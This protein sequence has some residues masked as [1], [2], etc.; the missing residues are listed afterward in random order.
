[1]E[2]DR[3]KFSKLPLLQLIEPTYRSQIKK[4]K[5][6]YDTNKISVSDLYFCPNPA[7]RESLR[8][9]KMRNSRVSLKNAM[10]SLKKDKYRQT[11]NNPYFTD[12]YMDLFI[13]NC[14]SVA[15]LHNIVL[16]TRKYNKWARENGE[17]V[18]LLFFEKLMQ[19][20]SAAT[21]IQMNFRTY[22]TRRQDSHKPLIDQLVLKRAIY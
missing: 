13:F 15:L 9:I 11:R 20:V 14:P 22:L 5:P 8:I 21:R 17:P 10:D 3:L 16:K 1:M 19:Q 18:V 4:K 7:A 12:S 6:H 2:E